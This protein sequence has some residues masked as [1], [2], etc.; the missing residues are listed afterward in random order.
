MKQKIQILKWMGAKTKPYIKN[1]I[2]LIL[3]GGILSFARVYMAYISKDL[4]DSALE[5]NQEILIKTGSIFCLTVLVQIIIKWISADL[6]VRTTENMSGSLKEK[7]YRHLTKAGWREYTKYHTGDIQMRVVGDTQ[8]T[9][10][11]VIDGIPKG[12]TLFTGLIAAFL[13]L[14]YLN[15]ETAL[16][17]LFLGPCSLIFGGLV[18]SR[19]M[20]F[21]ES[22]QEAEGRY[23]A[24]LQE[25]LSHM[26]IIKT[27][28]REGD[29][30]EKL[31]QMQSEK[32][33]LSVKRNFS[34]TLIN[35]AAMMGV[36]LSFL[37]VFVWGMSHIFD[38]TL[39]VGTLTA[40]VQL[41]GQVL[42]PFVDMA[43]L[44]TSFL[45]AAGSAKRLMEIE[46]IQTEDTENKLGVKEFDEIVL[47]NLHFSYDKDRPLL[48]GVSASIKKGEIVG[49]IGASGQGKTTLIN[50]IMQLLRP[51]KGCMLVKNENTIYNM[52]QFS[53]RDLISYVPQG[54]TLFSG[55]IEENLNIGGAETKTEEKIEA[56]K[57]ACAWDFVNALKE[58]LTTVIGEYGI[59]LS[60][61]QAQRI[62]I[63]RALLKKAPLLILDEA[64]S[65]LDMNTEKVILQNISSQEGE[66]TCII[67]THRLSAL[68]YCNR[69]F[70]LENGTL[71]E[72]EPVKILAELNESIG[73]SC[74]Y[75]VNEA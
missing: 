58:G 61:G 49:L 57:D 55:T 8:V 18:G 68:K 30:I 69:V 63:A 51:E 15:K 23:R 46:R 71:K 22:T 1:L 27:F 32:K 26:L 36:G 25:C 65:A 73:F 16:I 29:S 3:M 34:T 64:T 60:E 14:L 17:T 53:V 67:I 31:R 6:S 66:R 47:D 50:L 45:S 10:N 19:Y 54:N 62:A 41:I 35:T 20:S 44:F 33:R 39:T 56:L 13:A 38:K 28:C 52:D 43:V 40:Y 4:I 21:H 11:G 75:S 42:M 37:V 74:F 70:R 48:K 24:Y 2:L 72:R 59:G 5:R 7:M 9:V 12:T